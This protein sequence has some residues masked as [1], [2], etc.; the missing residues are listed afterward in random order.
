MGKVIGIDLGTTNSCVAVKEGDHITVITNAE[1]ARTTPSVVAFTKDKDRLVGQLAKR[2]AIVNPER[3]ISSIKRKMGSDYRIDI[4]GVSQTP[5]Q[6]SAMIL[7]KLRRDA[8]EYLGEKIGQA[9]ITVPAYFTDAQ[10]QA[11]KDAGKIAGLEVLRIINEPTAAALAYGMDKGG[12]NKILVFDL[13]GG[14]FD[15]SV[16]D[17]GIE[18]GVIEVLA[19]SGD[20]LLGGD[21]WDQKIVDLMVSDFR[22]NEGIDL[23][24]DR[25][26]LQRLREAA[27]KAKIEL[28]TL[29]ETS[30]SLPFITADSSG[31]KHLEMSFTRARFEEITRPLLERVVE[32]TRRALNDSGLTR[33]EINKVLLVGGAT[34]MPMVQKKIMELLGKEPT[35][36]INPDE[37]V[38]V[39]AAIQGAILTGEHK[40]IILVDVTPLSLG[41]ETLGGVFTKIIDRNTAIPVSKSQIFST[42]SDSQPQV[43]IHVLQGE[44]AMAGDNV[45]LGKFFLDG[46]PPAPRGVPQI[47]V[48]FDIDVNGILNVSA[49]DK[50]TSREQHV[51]IQS[52]RLS[53]A[54]I[55]KMR[56]A[57]ED[58][59]EIDRKKKELVDAR[60]EADSLI[61]ST[62]K[63]LTDLGEKVTDTERASIQGEIEEVRSALAGEDS[64]EIRK[65]CEKLTK[66]LHE[67]S[68]RLYGQDAGKPGAGPEQPSESADGETVDAEFEE[69]GKS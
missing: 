34:R 29:S 18:D 7:Q 37:C 16:L 22:K 15:V 9:V 45:T 44:R 11:T 68:T 52:S 3:T 47:E 46:I 33:E 26:A 62:E 8:E 66:S 5:Q 2:Q 41:I 32:P 48:T 13:G 60:N 63:M 38:A 1:G 50:G 23:S 6:I 25:M 67:M 24:R 12:E 27:E 40:D 65:V 19:T 56:R 69:N 39:G 31:P 30:I 57:A 20:N 51:T 61:Y 14:T 36:G 17:V 49:R 64:G 59:L 28:S 4:D 53:E 55:E 42:A 21:D 43:E 58:N 54:E 35:K 10:R